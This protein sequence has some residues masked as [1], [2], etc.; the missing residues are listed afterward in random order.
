M[1]N[2]VGDLLFALEFPDVFL[3]QGKKSA[4]K[5]VLFGL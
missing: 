5:S 4:N 2:A 3:I 1:A